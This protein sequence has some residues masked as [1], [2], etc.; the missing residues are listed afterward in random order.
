M[1]TKLINDN[2]AFLMKSGLL[3]KEPWVQKDLL[4]KIPQDLAV[5]TI[6]IVNAYDTKNTDCTKASCAKCRRKNNH[7]KGFTVLI[8]EEFFALFGN[9]CGENEFGLNAFNKAKNDFEHNRNLI[10]YNN[11]ITPMLKTL[12]IFSIFINDWLPAA[13]IIDGEFKCF[14]STFP[15]LYE[16]MCNIAEKNEVLLYD[17]KKTA[18]VRDKEG[19]EKYETRLL[20]RYKYYSNLQ[21]L[22]PVP[23][24]IFPLDNKANQ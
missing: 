10:I 21:I 15:K 8:N 23:E 17:I 6:E 14:K 20:N 4:E 2:S 19:N 1:N 24:L 16:A 5:K 12:T 11:K 9:N 3:I 7:P 18:F 22:L 13:K